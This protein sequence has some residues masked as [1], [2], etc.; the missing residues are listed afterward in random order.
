MSH[1]VK[2]GAQLHEHISDFLGHCKSSFGRRFAG[3]LCHSDRR[4]FRRGGQLLSQNCVSWCLDVLGQ[5]IF[6]TWDQFGVF[7]P[8]YL[9]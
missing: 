4:S 9:R 6:G 2:G 1:L 7:K 5:G 8:P 3:E